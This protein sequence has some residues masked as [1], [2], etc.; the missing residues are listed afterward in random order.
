MTSFSD[1][2]SGQRFPDL[3]A[4]GTLDGQNLS[5]I[6]WF[7]QKR[8]CPKYVARATLRFSETYGSLVQ[9][10]SSVFFLDFL[11]RSPY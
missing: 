11:P 2:S 8:I 4:A 1:Q 9:I 3:T 10:F 5:Y 7:L 6:N